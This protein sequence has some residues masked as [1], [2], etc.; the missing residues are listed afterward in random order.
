MNALG[1][2][3][4]EEALTI[5]TLIKEDTEWGFQASVHYRHGESMA[6]RRQTVLEKE[7]RVLSWSAGSR[8]TEPPGLAGASETSKLN[9]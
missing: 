4:C 2:H 1:S 8:K 3:G 6:T 5:A 7:L 9:Q